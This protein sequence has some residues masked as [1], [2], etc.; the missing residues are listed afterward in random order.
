[1]DFLDAKTG[2][3]VWRGLAITDID[4]TGENPAQV[5]EALNEILLKLPAPSETG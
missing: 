3:L 5:R 4:E 2:K 1:L